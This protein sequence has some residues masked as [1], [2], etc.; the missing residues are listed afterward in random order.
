MALYGLV[1]SLEIL[2]YEGD[3]FYLLVGEWTTKTFGYD[4]DGFRTGLDP[5]YVEVFPGEPYEGPLFGIV[6]SERI[7]TR[8]TVQNRNG[9]LRGDPSA[10]PALRDKSLTVR[11]VLQYYK[12]P[13][14][15][16]S[17]QVGQ[18]EWEWRFQ[19]I[20]MQ[21]WIVTILAA[22]GFLLA[23]YLCL[24]RPS[25]RG[26]DGKRESPPSKTPGPPEGK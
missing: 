25:Q 10:D 26:D 18:S 7:K 15:S 2:D 22:V 11:I 19:P 17:L 4:E 20:L 8:F 12:Q 24:R 1:W 21:V 14:E 9:G 3:H 6:E 23:T 13:V 16:L 5:I